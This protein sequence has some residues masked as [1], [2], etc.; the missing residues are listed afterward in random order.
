[1]VTPDLLYQ[2]IAEQWGRQIQSLHFLYAG[3]G[4]DNG[5]RDGGVA[6]SRHL[7]LSSLPASFIVIVVAA[8]LHRHLWLPFFFCRRLPP[9]H[10][11]LDV[12]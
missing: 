9:S 4:A 12:S 2:D 5:E 3:E 8:L 11:S 7:L 6:Q 10:G 1:M